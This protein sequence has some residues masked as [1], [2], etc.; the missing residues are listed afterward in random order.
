MAAKSKTVRRTWVEALD[1]GELG[2][3]IGRMN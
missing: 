1:L 2:S 3:P